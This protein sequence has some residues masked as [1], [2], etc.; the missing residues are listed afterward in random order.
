MQRRRWLKRTL[1]IGVIGI[2]GGA[3][4]VWRR[5]ALL[6]RRL[7]RS[8]EPARPTHEYPQSLQ[9]I[10]TERKRLSVLLSQKKINTKQLGAAF[11]QLMLTEIF[12]FWY[13][14]PWAFS[15]TSD[16]PQSGHIA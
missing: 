6:T 10:S 7:Y 3:V 2:L 8:P 5:P 12:P 11:T 9:R 16:T 13:G 14:T 4:V 1:A 15:G